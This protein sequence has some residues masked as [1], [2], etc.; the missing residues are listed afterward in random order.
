MPNHASMTC[1]V[2]A[3]PTHPPDPNAKVDGAHLIEVGTI[4]NLL[5]WSFMPLQRPSYSISFKAQVIQ[6][7]AQ[8]TARRDAQMDAPRVPL[9]R[10][11]LAQIHLAQ[12]LYINTVNDFYLCLGSYRDSYSP[13]KSRNRRCRGSCFRRTGSLACDN[14]CR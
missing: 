6:E 3:R 9:R 4:S 8:P 5:S 2:C 1:F 10:P 13:I 7:C 14:S 12:I 11:W